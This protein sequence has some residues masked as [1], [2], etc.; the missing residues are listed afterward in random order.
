M[1]YLFSEY[2]ATKAR[3]VSATMARMIGATKAQIGAT[4]ARRVP[5]RAGT[6]S[7]KVSRRG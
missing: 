6:S 7:L 2:D 3:G 5:Q 4:Q 1:K